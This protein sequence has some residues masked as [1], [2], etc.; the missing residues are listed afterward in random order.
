MVERLE[1][2]EL[3][4]RCMFDGLVLGLGCRGQG[5]RHLEVRKGLSPRIEQVEQSLTMMGAVA[6][7]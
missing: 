5:R 6:G 4:P 2:E 7:E 1:P 3:V